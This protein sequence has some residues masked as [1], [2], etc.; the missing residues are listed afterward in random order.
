MN[1]LIALLIMVTMLLSCSSVEKRQQDPEWQR[2]HSDCKW[3][4]EMKFSGWAKS[5]PIDLYED[6]VSYISAK[7]A[8]SKCMKDRGYDP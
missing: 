4:A 5:D 6:L 8:Y 7:T 2:A 3:I 1:R